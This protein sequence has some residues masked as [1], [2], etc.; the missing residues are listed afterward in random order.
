M[1]ISMEEMNK[2]ATLARLRFSDE[3][4]EQFT[5]DMDEIIAFAD[6]INQSVVG[7]TD[8]IKD[9]GAKVVDHEELRKDEVEESLPNE[10]IISN[11]DGEN[12]YF[13]VKKVVK[14]R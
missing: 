4:L 9:V 6:T 2:L 14:G 1:S 13:V 3:E 10:K 8:D 5:K 7:G 11:V 12:G